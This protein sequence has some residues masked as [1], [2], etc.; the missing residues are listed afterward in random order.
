[1]ADGVFAMEWLAGN[2]RWPGSSPQFLPQLNER[3]GCW[4]YSKIRTLV[5]VGGKKSFTSVASVTA[6]AE[7]SRVT[8]GHA[9]HEPFSRPIDRGN[10]THPTRFPPVPC[11]SRCALD[12]FCALIDSETFFLPQY[13]NTLSLLSSFCLFSIVCDTQPSEYPQIFQLPVDSN[14][15]TC[16]PASNLRAA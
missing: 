10:C 14:V 4:M 9:G 3:K 1:M 12:V 15:I 2:L 13:P 8:Q 6:P 11:S 16:I 5:G 7:G